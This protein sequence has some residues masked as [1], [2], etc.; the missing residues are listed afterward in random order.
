MVSGKRQILIIDDHLLFADGLELILGQLGDDLD[1]FISCDAEQVL[2]DIDTLRT[3]ELVIIDLHMPGVD[4]FNFLRAV[5]TQ[6]L[7]VKVLV[8]SG[9]EDQVEIER[10][11]GLGAMGFIPKETK[12]SEVLDG[13]VTVLAGKRYL[14]KHWEGKIDWVE[15]SGSLIN[16]E[17][18][19]IGPRQIEVLK[20]IKDGLQNKQIALVMGVSVSAVKSHIEILY[21]ALNVNNRTACVRAASERGLI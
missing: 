1:V 10:A 17:I 4:G 16:H 18:D 9:V 2:E 19:R 8:I 12:G 3:Y 21:K 5:R 15:S 6:A 7:D 13:V 14:P 11:L 20:L